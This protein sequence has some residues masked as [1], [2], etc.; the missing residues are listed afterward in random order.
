MKSFEYREAREDLDARNDLIARLVRLRVESGLTQKE[1]AQ[2]MGVKQ[3]M[4]SGFENGGADPR[5]STLQRYARAVCARLVTDLD[6]PPVTA[7]KPRN[8]VD[9]L[10]VTDE[11]RVE[12]EVKGSPVSARDAVAWSAARSRREDFGL[13]S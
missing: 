10:Y 1:V 5:L 11:V 13:A 3:P 2:R 4:V 7:W 8:H 9:F 6:M 12:V